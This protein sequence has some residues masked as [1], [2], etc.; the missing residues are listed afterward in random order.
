MG[1]GFLSGQSGQSGGPPFGFITQ[2]GFSS[3]YYYNY[4]AGS[5]TL[6]TTWSGRL[7]VQCKLT[8]NIK[9]IAGGFIPASSNYKATILTELDK[10]ITVPIPEI[11]YTLYYK[12]TKT[13]GG[14]YVTITLSDKAHAN[15][16]LNGCYF[17]LV[18][19]E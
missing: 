19:T 1:Q 16:G 5:T 14:S 8:D 4:Q 17:L 12:L 3:N 15:I 6:S 2:H 13:V 18:E 10:E 11:G 7:Y 9:R